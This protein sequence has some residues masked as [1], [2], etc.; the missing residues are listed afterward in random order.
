MT[1]SALRAFSSVGI[2]A[3]MRRS[4]SS[5]V[6]P[7]RA[8]KR[9]SWHLLGGAHHDGPVH[10]IQRDPGLEE[11]P[12][13]RRPPLSSPC[14]L[15]SLDLGTPGLAMRG[16]TMASSAFSGLLS[17]KT[18]RASRGA[19]DRPS[20]PITSGP[21]RWRISSLRAGSPRPTT[22]RANRLVDDGGAHSLSR[23]TTVP[24]RAVA[25]PP[26]SPMSNTYD[27]PPPL[28]AGGAEKNCCGRTRRCAGRHGRIDGRGNP[29]P[30]PHTLEP[31]SRN[32]FLFARRRPHSPG[33]WTPCARSP[34]PALPTARRSRNLAPGER[35]RGA[36]GRVPARKRLA[37]CT[38]S[39]R[40]AEMPNPWSSKVS[41]PALPPGEHAAQTSRRKTPGR[42][43]RSPRD[44]AL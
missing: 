14:A 25:T 29:L 5:S 40:A 37:P 15:N 16:W 31:G 28:A 13:R 6:S 35:R 42:T 30:L 27:H 2:W 34:R 38:C 22:S 17:S 24:S 19:I 9:W 4:A 1:A 21:N 26:V 11:K 18:M 20:S 33:N 23:R 7:L 3:A 12:A 44:A 8:I 36:P 43:D 39:P 10:P 32:L 41:P